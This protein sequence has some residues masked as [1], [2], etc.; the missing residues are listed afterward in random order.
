MI[1]DEVRVSSIPPSFWNPRYRRS[2]YLEQV[3]LL[4]KDKE[5][6]G[7]MLESS[8][9]SLSLLAVLIDQSNHMAKTASRAKFVS[10]STGR[11]PRRN[12]TEHLKQYNPSQGKTSVTYML[13]Y[14]VRSIGRN[15]T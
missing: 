5:D 4:Q 9:M 10:C 15:E 12:S 3:T 1:A 8:E 6:K 13:E 11:G 7:E 14:T 2:L